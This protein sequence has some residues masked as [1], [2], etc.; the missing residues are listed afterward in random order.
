MGGGDR[1]RAGAD[2]LLT[3]E[4]FDA[5]L[6]AIA[7][8]V[9]LKS[10]YSLGHARAVADLAAAAGATLGL[11]APE[12]HALQRA[13]LVHCYGKL[14]VSN[15]ILDK[16]EPLTRGERERLHLVPY[17]TH[18]ML[19]QSPALREIGDLAAQYGER[20]DGSGYPHGSR[21]PRALAAGAAPR[22]RRTPTSRCSSHGR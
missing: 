17:L 11:P 18:R 22:P 20:L 12:V 14:G 8:F 7:D 3:E 1:V 2:V 6:L 21:R 10:P 5:A 16:R 15:A 19:R 9:D 4:Q 13:A